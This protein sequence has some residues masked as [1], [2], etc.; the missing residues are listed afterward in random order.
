MRKTLILSALF[1]A[2]LPAQA[3]FTDT[4][5]DVLYNP[6]GSTVSSGT[7]SI[8]GPNVTIGSTTVLGKTKTVPV[9]GGVF[10]T[11]LVPNDTAY[12]VNSAY[13]FKL[14]NGSTKTC[15]FPTSSSPLQLGP[16]CVDG[17]PVIP[18]LSPVT[19]GQIG[20]GTAGNMICSNGTVAYWC[21]RYGD[22][23]QLWDS[24]LMNWDAIAVPWDSM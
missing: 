22:P 5:A 19:P 24:I 6:D 12:P 16:Y 7:I 3:P 20:G 9:A 15:T 10:T 17:T 11:K 8:Q 2:V 18:S 4:I 23:G 1:A 21:V 14:P 13:I